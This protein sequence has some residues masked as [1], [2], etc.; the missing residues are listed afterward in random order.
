MLVTRYIC[1]TGWVPPAECPQLC[2]QRAL[3]CSSL[4]KSGLV[5]ALIVIITCGTQS[6]K[7]SEG[8]LVPPACGKCLLG[9]LYPQK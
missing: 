1:K 5:S 3:L 8:L 6:N 2:C 4:V 9:V 7:D